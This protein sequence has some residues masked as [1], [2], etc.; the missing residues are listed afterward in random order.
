MI[1]NITAI[2]RKMFLVSALVLIQ[3]SLSH[4]GT[5]TYIYDDLDRIYQVCYGSTNCIQYQYDEIGNLL[6]KTPIGNVV[7]ITATSTGDGNIYP[8]GTTSLFNNGTVTYTIVPQPGQ[9]IA[10]VYVDGVSQGPINTYPF[11][12]VTINHTI[13]AT[14]MNTQMYPISF[15]AGANGSLSGVAVQS[16]SYNGSTT[17]VSAV[18][19]TG[20]YLVNW[21]GTGGFVTTTSNPLIVGNVSTAQNITANFS[22]SL[23][24]VTF[25]A[26][27]NGA[28][29]GATAQ[30]VNYNGSTTAVTAVPVQGYYFV[31]WTG[32]GGFV[33]NTS[34]PLTVAN[35]T[36]AQEITANFTS[37][38]VRLARTTP[39]YFNSINAA[40]SAAV[41]GDVI[42]CQAQVFTENLTLNNNVAVTLDGGYLPGYS[43]KSGSTGLVGSFTIPSGGGA[44]TVGD[45]T[46]Q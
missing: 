40:Y 12:N 42:Q 19:A 13:S 3:L 25:E 35:V 32:T 28:I 15:T 7:S 11:S 2:L 5:V 18:P 37:Y 39:V 14:F 27:A 36:A 24:P 26:V 43:D 1:K 17:A 20:Y 38:P 4:A 29:S 46:L 8:S 30:T 23:L 34:N 6:S 44:V 16:V 22:N 10:A 31:N 33:T 21:T 9:Q 41:N 45:F